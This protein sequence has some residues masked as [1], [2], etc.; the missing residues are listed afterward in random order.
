MITSLTLTDFRSYASATLPSPA[1]PVVLH[2]PNGAGK[3]NLLEALSLFTPGKGLRAATA[4]EMGRREPGEVGGRAWAVALTLDQDGDEV[5]LGTGVQVAGAG[6]RMVRIEGETA[7]PGR[8]RAASA[9]GRGSR[10]VNSEP[11]PGWLR[12]DTR[13]PISST[14]SRTMASPSPEPP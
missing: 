10:S 13:P 3:T 8:L 6:R 12:A 9:G 14:R 4:Q 7:Q 5:R 1:G 2:G 11:L